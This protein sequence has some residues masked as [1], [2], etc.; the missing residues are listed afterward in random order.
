MKKVLLAMLLLAGCRSA[1]DGPVP[2]AAPKVRIGT[3]ALSVRI[4]K[5]YDERRQGLRQ[6]GRLADCDALLFCHARERYQHYWYTDE[7]LPPQYEVAF[8]SA[9]GVI[10]EIVPLAR[11]PEGVTSTREC[12][13]ALITRPE[14]ISRSGA[15]AGD[16]VRFEPEIPA[17]LIEENPVVEIEGHRFYV[18]LSTTD[19]ER[20]RGLMYRPRMSRD[21]GMLFAYPTA[22]TRSYWMGNCY[23][24]LSLAFFG[25]DLKIFKIHDMNTYPDPKNPGDDYPSYPS[26]EPAQYAL[27]VTYGR[28]RELG[29]K[30]GAV[31]K[32][33]PELSRYP[34]E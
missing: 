33:P 12:K 3:A 5:T 29:I 24:P 20:Q 30:P 11:S 32:L 28:F 23:M 13:Y 22:R 1:Q 25:S 9:A 18:E 19:A 16:R 7:V 15:R 8:I 17:A 14:S 26:E 4:L 27:E 2:V 10:T 21:D 34:P 31:V 6:H